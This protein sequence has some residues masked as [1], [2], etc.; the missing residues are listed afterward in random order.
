MSS[1]IVHTKASLMLATGFGIGGILSLN[2]SMLQPVVGALIGV[3]ITPDLDV[4]NGFIGD[5]HIRRFSYWLEKIWDLIWLYYRKS[6]KHGG[7]LSH[8]PVISTFG[9]IVYLYFVVI[10]V[11][12][13]IIYFAFKPNWDLNWVFEAYWLNILDCWKIIIGMIGSDII[14]WALD[15]LTTE[16]TGGTERHGLKA[17]FKTFITKFNKS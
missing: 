15:V 5:A 7:P 1:G 11:P 10:V 16:H 8:F 14:H 4:D 6:L 17:K 12:H 9:R 3:I 2:P 13:T